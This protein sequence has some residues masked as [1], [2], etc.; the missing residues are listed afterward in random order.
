MRAASGILDQNMPYPL[1]GGGGGGSGGGT[2]PDSV[3]FTVCLEKN[4]QKKKI[5]R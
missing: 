3:P 4:I 1:S 5:K 2:S